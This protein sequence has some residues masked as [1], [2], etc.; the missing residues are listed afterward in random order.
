MGTSPI[1]IVICNAYK[2]NTRPRRYG[3]NTSIFDKNPSPVIPNARN[4]TGPIQQLAASIDA[5]IPPRDGNL[6]FIYLTHL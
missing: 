6:S 1:G 3:L 4:R 2:L 5:A